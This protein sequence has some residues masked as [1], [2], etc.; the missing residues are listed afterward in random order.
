MNDTNEI[1]V[2]TRGLQTYFPVTEGLLRRT[3]GHVRAVDGVDLSI[4]RGE[5]VA[6][7]G[8][9]GCGKSTLGNSILGL[10]RPTGGQ[11]WLDN[12]ELDIAQPSSW[13]PFRRQFQVIFQDPNTSLNPRHT[14]FEI[15]AEPLLAHGVARRSNVRSAVGALLELV[16]LSPEYMARYPHAFSGG[17]RQRLCIAR[18]VGLRPKLII[19]DEVTAALDVSVQAQ[20]ITL[21]KELQKEMGLAMLFISHDLSVVKAVSDIVHVMYLGSIVESAARASLFASPAHPYTRALLNSIP[22]LHRGQRPAVL[23]GEV[24]SPVAKPSG[25]PFHTR[26]P[27]VEARCRSEQPPQTLRS[28]SNSVACFFPLSD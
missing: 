3:V 22:T 6:V 21:L 27:R 12:Q 9:S 1:V 13:D 24:P 8:E 18:A 17:Q 19:C 7:V 5:T 4:R 16:G 28:E 25:C 15:L 26:C 20:I 10:V 14:V 11:L 23:A 2:A